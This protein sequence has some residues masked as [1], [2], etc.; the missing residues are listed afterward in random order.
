V[1]Y[2]VERLDLKTLSTPAAIFQEATEETEQT[3]PR[4]ARMNADETNE[5]ICSDHYKR[6]RKNEDPFPAYDRRFVLLVIFCLKV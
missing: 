6:K 1:T 5:P 4:M 2:L 3:L